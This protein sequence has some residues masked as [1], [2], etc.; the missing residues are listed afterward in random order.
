MK[1]V[2]KLMLLALVL[3]GV[4]PFLLHGSN[5]KP[6]FSLDKLTLPNLSHLFGRA[7]SDAARVSK[8]LGDIKSTAGKVL[9]IELDGKHTAVHKWRDK[10]GVWHFS[11]KQN[12]HGKDE[13]VLIN[14]N[15]NV[16]QADPVAKA[17]PN[18]QK[19]GTA[20]DKKENTKD[21]G[22]SIPLPTTIPMK[23]I[24]KLIRDTQAL[25]DT[26]NKRYRK[27]QKLLDSLQSKQ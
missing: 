27:Q 2:F 23:D 1:R 10:H 21:A 7:G 8:T 12:P 11:D 18:K 25:K 22:P 9:P 3:V 16:V 5:G 19:S 26:L 6:L 20:T 13:V 15:T 4:S 24:P 14:T 17:I